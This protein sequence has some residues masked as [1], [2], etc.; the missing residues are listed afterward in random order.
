[1]NQDETE[2]R[3][4]EEPIFFSLGGFVEAVAKAIVDEPDCVTVHEIEGTQSTLIELEVSK[5][6]IGIVVGK[7]GAMAAALRTI[8]SAAGAKLKKRVILDIID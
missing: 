5:E 4:K 2:P 3:R 8:L 1:M 6:D 7:R